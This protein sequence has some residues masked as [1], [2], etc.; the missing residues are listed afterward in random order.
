M[1]ENVDHEGFVRSPASLI[2][3][4]TTS[5]ASYKVKCLPFPCLSSAEACILTYK[6]INDG[7]RTLQPLTAR[8]SREQP[9]V[10]DP[11]SGLAMPGT[12]GPGM[13]CKNWQSQGADI[14]RELTGSERFQSLALHAEV[15]SVS[16]S[17]NN[18]WICMCKTSCKTSLGHPEEPVRATQ[19]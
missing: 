10:L 16:S 3:Q 19:L 1:C 13:H 14:T 18:A 7:Q 8:S 5:S 12:A 17:M 6:V 11:V 15:S 4:I 2:W 9:M